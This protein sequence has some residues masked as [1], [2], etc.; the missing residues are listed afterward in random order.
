MKIYSLS[1]HVLFFFLSGCFIVEVS[2]YTLKGIVGEKI[3][4]RIY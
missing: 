4:K 1:K 3:W 2:S